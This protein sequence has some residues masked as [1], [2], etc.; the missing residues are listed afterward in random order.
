[1]KRS[2]RPDAGGRRT[3]SVTVVLPTRGRSELLR[4]AVD[5]VV[6]QHYEG[7]IECVVAVDGTEKLSTSLAQPSSPRRTV[8]ILS[9]P[10]SNAA[11]VR[12]EGAA[13]ATGDLLAFCDD[14]DEWLPTKLER[15]VEAF[16]SSGAVAATCGIAVHYRK[17]VRERVSD[18]EIVRLGDLL[19]SRRADMHTSTILVRT[20]D[21]LDPERI[22]PF[23]EALPGSHAEDYDWLLRAAQ[24]G[25]ILAL[26]EALVE[27][28][29]HAGSYFQ[30]QWQEQREALTYLLDKHREFRGDPVGLGRIYGQIAF[31]AAAA[32]EM[33]AGLRWAGRCLSVDWRQPRAYL[34][35][36]TSLRLLP[37]GVLLAALNAHGRGV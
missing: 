19:R 7:E 33:R 23:D 26:R 37:P 31:A 20:S 25:P 27:V 8:R 6:H 16:A 2:A 18:R 36:A 21:F 13:S 14:D 1:M 12:N 10:R 35:I 9:A 15:Q 17:Q 29:W 24:K 4:R 11:A 3:P 5:A 32:G 28:R 30:R 22:G 34:A